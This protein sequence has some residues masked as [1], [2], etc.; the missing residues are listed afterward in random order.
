MTPSRNSWKSYCRVRSIEAAT[1][2]TKHFT[3]LGSKIF[4]LLLTVLGSSDAFAPRQSILTTPIRKTQVHAMDPANIFETA[5][6]F[7]SNTSDAL[8][9]TSGEVSYSRASYYTILGLYALS[10]PGIWSTIKRST[11]AKVKRKT[12]VT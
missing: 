2:S 10:F 11:K 9:G 8:P 4:F 7:L 12:Y 3:M 6:T 5:S 1:I